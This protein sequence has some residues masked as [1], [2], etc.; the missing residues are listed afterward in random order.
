VYYPDEGGSH[1]DNDRTESF[2]ISYDNVQLY[3]GFAGNET[4]REERDWVAHPTVLSGDIDGDDVTDPNGVVTDTANIS[5]ANAHH[6]LYLD[7]E[8]NQSISGATVIDGFTVTAGNANGTL[9]PENL[10]GGLYCAGSGIGHGCSPT[11]TNVTFSGNTTFYGGGMFN[12]GY[13]GTSSPALTNVTFSGN[14]ATDSGGGMYN[15]GYNGTS[16]PTLTNVTFSGNTATYYGGGMYNQGYFGASS[17]ALT[18]VTFSGNTALAG[19]GMFNNGS[20]GGT[21]M[22]ALTNVTFSGNTATVYGG[23]M[24]NYG[25]SGNSSPVLVNS[26]LWGDSGGEIYNVDATPTVTYSIV[27]GGYPGGTNI[28][29]DDPLLG[30]LGDFGGG[31][32]TMPLLPGSPA[33]NAGDPASCP[34]T[35]QRGVERPQGAGCDVGAY[36]SRGFTLIKLGGDK[37][38][39]PIDTAF[40]VPLSV[41]LSET[42]G[43]PLPD[44]VIIFTAPDIGASIAPPTTVTTTTDASGVASL[45]VTANGTPGSYHVTASAAGV[46]GVDFALTNVADLLSIAKAVTPSSAAPGQAVTYTLSFAN[47]SYIPAT[48]VVITDLLPAEIEV[49]GVISSGVPAT[50]SGHVPPYVWQVADLA[51]GDSGTIT[52][53]GLIS[54][55]LQGGTVIA[56]RAEIGSDLPEAVTANNEGQADVTVVNLFYVYLPLIRR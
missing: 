37:Q 55:G 4:A 22:P 8:T 47:V 1:V 6:V 33:I 11:L 45:P 27:Q 16:S 32:A 54:G 5:G 26:I 30:L 35:D 51:P 38:A 49:T 9:S 15:N 3:G 17:P 41:T 44:A 25:S 39:A 10:G 14:T 18:N 36:E 46:A 50:D 40:A 29:T 48:G 7:G 13:N 52:I 43:H 31:T 56:N 28:I 21:S 34:G 2:R 53:T 42:G 23:G 24:V 19:G 20:H 12:E